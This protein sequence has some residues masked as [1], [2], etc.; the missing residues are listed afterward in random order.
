LIFVVVF[1]VQGRLSAF[2]LAHSEALWQFSIP[3]STVSFLVYTAMLRG[4]SPD[5]GP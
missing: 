3:V 1:A 2:S 4:R 5:R